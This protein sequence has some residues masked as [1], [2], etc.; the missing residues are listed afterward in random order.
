VLSWFDKVSGKLV[1]EEVLAAERLGLARKLGY[2]DPERPIG[3][4]PADASNLAIVQR[5]A[6][7]AIDLADYDYIVELMMTEGPA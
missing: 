5:V 3:G 6:R 7:A 1:G 4:T 2:E